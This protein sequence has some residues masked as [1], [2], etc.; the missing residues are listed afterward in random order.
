[1]VVALVLAALLLPLLPL[2]VSSVGQGYFFPQVVPETIGLRAWRLILAPG[3]ETWPALIDTVVLAGT[4]TL[5]ALV[6]ALP[7]G[8]ALG[9]YR[10]RGRHTVE[11]LLLAPVLVPPIAVA[12]GLYGALLRVGLTGS[13]AGVVL[14]HLVPVLPYVV[15]VLAGTFANLDPDYEAQARSLGAGPVAVFRTVTL[16][17]IAP[18]LATA[19]FFA[20]LVTWGQYALTLVIG[21]GQVVTLPILLF[22]SA[23]GGDTAVTSALA[24]FT[25]APALLLLAV[26]AWAVTGRA[27]PIG[28]VR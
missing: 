18:G 22:A 16:P 21:G 9:L 10:F 12:I 20:F 1:V 25:A 28:G 17:A 3:A 8:R 13:M 6:I 7:A 2:A 14:V 5:V 11:F 4:V 19:A 27:V 15:L 24:I 26:N 23:S